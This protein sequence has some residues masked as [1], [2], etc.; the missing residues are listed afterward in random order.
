M[1]SP[2][3]RALASMLGMMF[4]RSDSSGLE[5]LEK[6]EARTASRFVFTDQ[7]RHQIRTMASTAMVE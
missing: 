5:T 3:D 1:L 2:Q 6:S 4:H 7:T